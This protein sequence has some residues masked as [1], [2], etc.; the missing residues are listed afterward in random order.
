MNTAT[1]LERVNLR[2]NQPDYNPAEILGMADIEMISIIAPAIVNKERNYWT[3]YVDLELGAGLQE[4]ALPPNLVGNSITDIMYKQGNDWLSMEPLP[5]AELEQ[6]DGIVNPRFYT[7]LRSGVR[8]HRP[9]TNAET[10]RV[11]YDRKPDK[12]IETNA[13][14]IITGTDDAVGLVISHETTRLTARPSDK[15]IIRSMAETH[16]IKLA[17]LTLTHDVLT[18]T[19]TVDAGD[20]ARAI[21][22]D[23]RPGDHVDPQGCSSF[24]ETPDNF[25]NALIELTCAS[26]CENMGDFQ[27]ADR[28]RARA[29]AMLDSISDVGPRV[30]KDRNLLQNLWF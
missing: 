24:L 20:V 28:H 18:S 10:F 1:F 7:V 3:E 13:T 15:Y 9:I 12:L 25:S 6:I 11:W 2:S 23:I 19:Y 27:I 30:R 26:I 17:D 14:S 22:A 29:Q 4:L 16:P 21:A 8:V 5:I